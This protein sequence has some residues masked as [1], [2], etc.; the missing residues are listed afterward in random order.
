M[1]AL[2]VPKVALAILLAASIG[3]AF[4]GAPP[5]HPRRGVVPCGVIG[6]SAYLGSVLLAAD[7]HPLLACV[8]VVTAVEAFCLA[9]WLSR[10]RDDGGGEPAPPTAHGPVD[11]AEF[12]RQRA[13]WSRPRVPVGS[14]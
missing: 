5:A 12:D 2:L 6:L 11:W 14:G 10:G 1:G 3:R 7:R 13:G 4:F 8:L 9:V